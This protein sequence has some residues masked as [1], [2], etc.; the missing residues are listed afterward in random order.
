VIVA[1]QL[2]INDSPHLNPFLLGEET[3]YGRNSKTPID[4][5]IFP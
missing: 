5:L 1:R 3:P 2:E 4:H